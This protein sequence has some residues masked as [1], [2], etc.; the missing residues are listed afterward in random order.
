MRYCKFFFLLT[1]KIFFQN[2]QNFLRRNTCKIKIFF[3]ICRKNWKTRTKLSLSKQY[4]KMLKMRSEQLK[5]IKNVKI[6]RI[7]GIFRFPGSW[8]SGKKGNPTR[9]PTCFYHRY[10]IPVSKLA[11]PEPPNGGAAQKGGPVNS[12]YVV[13]LSQRM[14]KMP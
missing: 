10:V 4:N 7:T 6:S 11:P 2:S 1:I 13:L 5:I 8:K 14:I 12:Q 9:V 3:S